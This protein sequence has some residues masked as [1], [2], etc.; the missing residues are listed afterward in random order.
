MGLFS[1]KNEVYERNTK[2]AELQ[3]DM[4]ALE[5][6]NKKLSVE[7]AELRAEV[8]N[9]RS[10]NTALINDN[11]ILEG[12]ILAMQAEMEKLKNQ[13]F[14]EQSKVIEEDKKKAFELK[15]SASLEYALELKRLKFFCDKFKE[16]Y[17]SADE[18]KKAEIAGMLTDIIKE[19]DGVKAERD[20]KTS[21]DMLYDKF[22]IKEETEQRQADDFEFDLEQV[23]N[24]KGELDLEELC[25]E[26]GV[27]RG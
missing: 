3:S 21:V 7:N 15:Q 18:L 12:K 16:N 17:N 2:I 25:R 13:A 14:A 27:Y 23:M 6:K 5:K 20:T 11:S 26:L 19:C 9:L 24:P 1:R 10:T 4:E 22:G 8:N